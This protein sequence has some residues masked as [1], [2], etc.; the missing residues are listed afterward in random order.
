MGVGVGVGVTVGVAVG[1]SVCST[2]DDS[3]SASTGGI[4]DA[5]REC[6]TMVLTRTTYIPM[7]STAMAM[8]TIFCE[9]V[10]FIAPP[11]ACKYKSRI[12]RMQTNDV[13]TAAGWGYTGI[14]DEP[15]GADLRPGARTGV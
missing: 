15:D 5:C 14:H 9:R 10:S 4:C 2:V 6:R 12:A 7:V 3:D 1:A 8:S 13:D 11:P